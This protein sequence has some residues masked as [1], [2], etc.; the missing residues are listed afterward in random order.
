MSDVSGSVDADLRI[1]NRRV[2]EPRIRELIFVRRGRGER[3]GF[4]EGDRAHIEPRRIAVGF[5]LPVRVP[6]HRGIAMSPRRN[7]CAA[8][9][10]QSGG[11]DLSGAYQIL[12]LRAAHIR[13][14]PPPDKRPIFAAAR[15]FG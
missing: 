15:L 7:T 14:S 10:T 1:A 13:P 2:R 12:A 6:R 11:D 5:E 3:T 8:T 9:D 4:A